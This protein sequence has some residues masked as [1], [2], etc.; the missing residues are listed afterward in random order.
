MPFSSPP[1][2]VSH[3]RARQGSEMAVFVLS[4]GNVSTKVRIKGPRQCFVMSESKS[5]FIAT[6]NALHFHSTHVAVSNPFLLYLTYTLSYRETSRT[7][8]GEYSG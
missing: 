7:T 5:L 3:H 2:L 8:P 6:Y 4:L 1:F